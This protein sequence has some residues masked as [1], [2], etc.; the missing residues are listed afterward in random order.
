[1]IKLST[2]VSD[3]HHADTY[4]FCHKEMPCTCFKVLFLE[5]C[6]N[7]MLINGAFSQ[8]FSALLCNIKIAYASLFVIVLPVSISIVLLEMKPC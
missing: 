2:S 8:N 5:V 4:S 7:M 1:M 3:L 6:Q